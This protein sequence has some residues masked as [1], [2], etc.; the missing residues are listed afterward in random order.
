MIQIRIAS[1]IEPFQ[2]LSANCLCVFDHF[3]ELALKG[4]SISC[5]FNFSCKGQNDLPVGHITYLMLYHVSYFLSVLVSV[6]LVS[7]STQSA[8]A[9]NYVSVKA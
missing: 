1:Q 6:L 5:N 8:C 4:L 7:Y 3:V 2:P 9:T